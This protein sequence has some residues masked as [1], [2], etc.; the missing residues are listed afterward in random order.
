MPTTAQET[1]LKIKQVADE[2]KLDIKT[3]TLIT[4]SPRSN[5]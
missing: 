1:L 2:T 3:P 5:D 4:I